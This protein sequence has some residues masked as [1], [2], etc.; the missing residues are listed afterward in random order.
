MKK[1]VAII[2][3]VVL[4][5]GLVSLFSGC[6]Q[7]ASVEKDIT[8][9][10]REQGSGTREAFD[11][12][13]TDG[14]HFLQEKDENGKTV[15]NTTK[16]AV[17]L[18]KTGEVLS[19]VAAEKN[20][21]GY[22][23]LGSVNDSIL[24]VKVNGVAASEQTVLDGSYKIQRPFVMMTKKGVELSARAADFMKFAKSASVK[25]AVKKSEVIFLENPAQR[26]N[27]GEEPIEVGVYEK[28]ATLP[29]GGKI[30]VRGSTSME[31]LIKNLAKAYADLYNEDAANIFDIEVQSSSVG[32]K[33]VEEDTTGNVIG[34]SSA[35]VVNESI[36]SFNIC[37]D[38]VAVI[39]HKENTK[40]VDLTLEQLYGIFS[41]SITKF[42]QVTAA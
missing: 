19:K 17:T 2:L 5:L 41:G 18:A 26:A 6:N 1:I 7:D 13:V 15:Y 4:T 20:A 9:V 35:K 14:V 22:I 32:R 10:A 3:S 42:S 24:T 36:D 28:L 25:D 31:K 38:A 12:V 40:V 21:I 11:K 27:D 33:V 29:E 30:V 23:S 34:L 39:V 16:T 8:V 37:L